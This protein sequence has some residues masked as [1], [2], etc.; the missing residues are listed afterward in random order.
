MQR[1]RSGHYSIS[2]ADAWPRITLP[3]P[4]LALP[5]AEPYHVGLELRSDG[6]QALAA[7]STTRAIETALACRTEQVRQPKVSSVM[8]VYHAA[9]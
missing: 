3:D 8:P 1:S 9:A 5:G 2:G 6:Y 7:N 4:A